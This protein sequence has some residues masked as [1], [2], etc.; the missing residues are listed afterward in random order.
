[1]AGLETEE[2]SD[3]LIGKHPFAMAPRQGHP[4]SRLLRNRIKIGKPCDF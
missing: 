3:K 1:M 4:I 2:K